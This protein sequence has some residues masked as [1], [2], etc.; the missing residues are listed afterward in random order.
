MQ[1]V[2]QGKVMKIIHN[3][4]TTLIQFLFRQVKIRVQRAGFDFTPG[5]EF[6]LDSEWNIGMVE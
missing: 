3:L 6:T 2:C 4:A 5:V 1:A